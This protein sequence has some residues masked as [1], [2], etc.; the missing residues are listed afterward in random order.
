MIQ[1]FFKKRYD[2]PLEEFFFTTEGRV[3]YKPY[4]YFGR[5]SRLVKKL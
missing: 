1:K 2:N 4:Q 3:I 5:V